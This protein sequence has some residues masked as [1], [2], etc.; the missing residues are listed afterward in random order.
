VV[1]PRCGSRQIADIFY[2]FPDFTAIEADLKA[3]RIVL[4]GCEPQ[5]PTHHCHVCG[6]EFEVL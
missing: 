1:C 3:G 4:G 2:G 6:Y 5:A